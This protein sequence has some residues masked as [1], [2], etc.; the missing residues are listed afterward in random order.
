MMDSLK[1]VSVLT[2]KQTSSVDKGHVVRLSV[3]FFFVTKLKNE[4]S[5]SCFS[6]TKPAKQLQFSGSTLTQL[7]KLNVE[8]TIITCLQR[9]C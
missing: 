4:M 8:V 9:R 3:I 2:T 6:L 5:L 1:T 7:L